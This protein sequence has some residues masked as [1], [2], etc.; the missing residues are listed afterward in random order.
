VAVGVRLTRD[1]VA[2]L[3]QRWIAAL[4]MWSSVGVLELALVSITAGDTL[5]PCGGRR[6]RN[7]VWD[8]NK[9]THL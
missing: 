7:G 6:P 8:L 9:F 3:I 2:V 1:Q 5:G 4:G